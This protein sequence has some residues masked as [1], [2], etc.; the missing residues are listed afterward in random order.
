MYAILK[1]HHLRA[2][3]MV[4]TSWDAG[5]IVVDGLRQLGPNATAAQLQHFILNLT[6]FAGVDGIYDFKKYPQR[7]LGPDA[8][9]V[10][11]YDIKTNSWKWLSKPGGAPL[12]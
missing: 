5:L 2:D 9:T 6:D 3:N 11:T 4:A 1:T 12:S 7:G 10:T 8:S